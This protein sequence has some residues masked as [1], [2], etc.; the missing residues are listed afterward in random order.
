MSKDSGHLIV[1]LIFCWLA[2]GFIGGFIWLGVDQVYLSK[3]QK[4]ECK[5]VDKYLDYEVFQKSSKNCTGVTTLNYISNF[6]VTYSA[7]E[8][9]YEEL[10]CW[11]GKECKI[12]EGKSCS[13][14]ACTGLRK[15]GVCRKY[16]NLDKNDIYTK[17]DIGKSYDCWYWKEDPKYSTLKL[18]RPSYLWSL[19]LWIP[20]SIFWMVVCCTYCRR[21][22]CDSCCSCCNSN[23]HRRIY[24]YHFQGTYDDSDI[25]ITRPILQVSE[26]TQEELAKEEIQQAENFEK[27]N[28]QFKFENQN[29]FKFENQNQNEK[30]IQIDYIYQPEIE[31]KPIINSIPQIGINDSD[32]NYNP[33]IDVGP[34]NYEI[35]NQIESSDFDPNQNQENKEF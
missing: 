14:K 21:L 24:P 26:K 22:D 19:F 8:N 23:R 27:E 20:S 2:F 10:S 5:I 6:Q 31:T 30:K 1:I 3:Y 15:N 12:S 33:N 25:V 13:V 9:D 17:F 16:V 11:F 28:N 32:Y 7:N 34:I 35:G 18:P 29:Q 4:T